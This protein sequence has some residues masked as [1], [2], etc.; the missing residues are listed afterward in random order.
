[1]SVQASLTTL[2]GGGSL[3]GETRCTTLVSCQITSTAIG[4]TERRHPPAP[5]RRRPGP[6]SAGA[7][8]RARTPA[9]ACERG[10]IVL[11]RTGLLISRGRSEWATGTWKAARELKSTNLIDKLGFNRF[12]P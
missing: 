1:M 12:S 6:G 7:R 11:M 9:S 5:A 10:L 4:L 8:S 3:V 2:V